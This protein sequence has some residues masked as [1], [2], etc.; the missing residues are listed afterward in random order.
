MLFGCL[1]VFV[2]QYSDIH[3]SPI[4]SV[5]ADL[6]RHHRITSNLDCDSTLI[7]ILISRFSIFLVTLQ[8]EG[9]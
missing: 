6:S 3:R 2:E 4:C 9:L 8:L 5:G 7:S 1:F